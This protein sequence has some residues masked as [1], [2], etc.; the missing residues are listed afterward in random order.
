MS[1]AL[2]DSLMAGEDDIV[3]KTGR[4]SVSVQK[5]SAVELA[6]Q[7][8]IDRRPVQCLRHPYIWSYIIYVDIH[9][10][11]VLYSRENCYPIHVTSVEVNLNLYFKSN[12]LR[13]RICS[14]Y[15][16]LNDGHCKLLLYIIIRRYVYLMSIWWVRPLTFTLTVMSPNPLII[17]PSK[18]KPATSSTFIDW[19]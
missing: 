4:L 12:S 14:R 19:C 11:I 7:L 9:S 6:G 5:K 1:S 17:H 15:C 2:T 16:D 10:C 8:I 3:M 18:T 13:S